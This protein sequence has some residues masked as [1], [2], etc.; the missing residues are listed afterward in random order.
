M[1]QTDE[2]DEIVKEIEKYKLNDSSKIKE[3]KNNI[4]TKLLFD[5]EELKIYNT[6]LTHYRFIDEIDEIRYGSYIRWFNISKN[7]TLE[8]LR[9]G[10]VV[11]IKHVKD[12]IQILCKNGIKTFFTLKMSQ[13]IIFQK[14][15]KQEELLIQ[16]LD[17]V[18]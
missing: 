6:L 13:C 10:F 1:N 12:D 18:K 17:H 15:T 3:I 4:L 5:T 16:I 9:G 7:V 11:D 14:N 8:L 2:M